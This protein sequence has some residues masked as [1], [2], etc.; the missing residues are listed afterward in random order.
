MQAEPGSRVLRA[1]ILEDNLSD[2]ELIVHELQRAGFRLEWVRVDNEAAYSSALNP[3]LDIILADYCLPQFDAIRALQLLKDAGFKIP[4]I[5]ITGSV[6]EENAVACIQRGAADYLIK[7]RLARL[8]PAVELA[9][10]QRDLESSK[11][12]T[13]IALQDSEALNRAVI[14][15]LNTKIAVLDSTGLIITVNDAWNRAGDT[16]SP[17]I[18]LNHSEPGA[19]ADSWVGVNYLGMCRRLAENGCQEAAR[20]MSGIQA[21]LNGSQD[22]FLLEYAPA[23][24]LDVQWYS[25]NVT[26]LTGT[27]GGAVI[28]HYDITS[29][30]RVEELLRTQSAALEAMPS[31]MLITDRAGKIAWVNPAFS[32]LTGYSSHEAVG[33]QSRLFNPVANETS[34]FKNMWNTL[35]AGSVWHNEVGNRRKDGSLYTSEV[36]IAPV[37]DEGGEITHFIDIEQDITERKQHEREL[38]TI[39]NVANALRTARTRSEM[40]PVIMDKLFDLLKAA[41]AS[42]SLYD[43]ASDEMVVALAH[44]PFAASSGQRTPAHEGVSGIIVSSRQIYISKDRTIDP[45]IVDMGA[46]RAFTIAGMPLIAQGQVIGIVWLGKTTDITPNEIR[47]LNAIADIA[48]NAIHRASLHEETERRLQRL[49]AMREIDNA[50][51]ASLDLNVTLTVLI[52]QVLH[53][54]NMDAGNVLLYTPDT[55]LLEYSV[56][57]GFRSL[58]T[59]S[60]RLLSQTHAQKAVLTRRIISLP[61]LAEDESGLLQKIRSRGEDYEAYFAAPLVAK[62]QVKGVLE[63]YKRTP[64]TPNSEWFGFLEM[65]SGQAAIAIDNAELFDNLQQSNIRLAMAY[66]ATIEG[67]SRALDLRDRET[68]GHTRRVTEMTLQ[69]AQAAGVR[70]AELI[71][72]RRGSLLHDIGKM[73]IPDAILLKPGAHNTE[74]WE[75]IRKHP[76]YAYELLSPIDF[77]HQALDI[78][79]CHHEHW[80]GCGY[81]RGLKGDQIPIAARIFSVI[82]VYDALISDRP[83]RSGWE[84]NKTIDYIRDQSGKLFDPRIVELFLNIVED[85][86][87]GE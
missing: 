19:A 15:S 36:T 65:I 28:S 40:L 53:Q 41:G 3:E 2:A 26:P 10:Q 48:A 7:D 50:I 55:Q 80:D 9:L 64:F 5:V 44:G 68:E 77:L 43:Q 21:V 12:S 81:P 71:H 8:G 82:D 60:S 76:T 79:Y 34:A 32:S 17:L 47:I 37:R 78:P 13:E 16:Q 39:V 51:T 73:A 24:G 27:S 66:D 61:N 1:L 59:R 72:M 23:G 56:G 20:A 31:A 83:Y 62:G 67:W 18:R 58:Y 54:L 11:K 87:N 49:I 46:N 74:E 45:R 14:N 63:L 69:L 75:I 4:F 33:H 70:E 30:K 57:V 29:R 35:Q 38:E 86:S 25:M 85:L 42:I 22:L 84:R 52:E 6:S